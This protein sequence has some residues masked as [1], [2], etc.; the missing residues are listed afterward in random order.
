VNGGIVI[1]VAFLF[2]TAALALRGL[3][4]GFSGEVLSLAGTV[5]GLYLA[6]TYAPQTGSFLESSF[7]LSSGWAYG[8]AL[9][10]LFVAVNLVTA[11]LARLVSVFLKIARLSLL[12]RLFGLAAGGAKSFLLLLLVYGAFLVAGPLVPLPWFEDSRSLH[13]AELV[14]PRLIP[15]LDDTFHFDQRSSPHQMIFEVP[16][17]DETL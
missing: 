16:P 7:G 5:G 10:A 6:F 9:V 12:D 8:V 1:D 4:R 11:A 17:A 2:L 14:W 3:F 13:L 15:Y